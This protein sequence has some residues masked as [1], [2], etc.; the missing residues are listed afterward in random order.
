MPINPT[1]SG[2]QLIYNAPGQSGKGSKS[3]TILTPLP[4]DVEALLFGSLM[5][6]YLAYLAIHARLTTAAALNESDCARAVIDALSDHIKFFSTVELD[7]FFAKEISRILSP[8]RD[9]HILCGHLRILLEDS[10]HEH[11]DKIIKFF[12]SVVCQ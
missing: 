9:L 3:E 2:L 11:K 4:D 7:E 5:K 6:K 1:E 10:N 12:K 8:K